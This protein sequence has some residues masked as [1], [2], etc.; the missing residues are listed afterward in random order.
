[1]P[2]LG[3]AAVSQVGFGRGCTPLPPLSP[4]PLEPLP[5]AV[6]PAALQSQAPQ[7]GSEPND[8]ECSI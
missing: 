6:E 1:M 5:P 3:R 8:A 7:T 2:P 4:G